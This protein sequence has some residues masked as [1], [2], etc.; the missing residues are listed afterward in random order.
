AP[1]RVRATRERPS[2]SELPVRRN[3]RRLRS[4]TTPSTVP[5]PPH[6]SQG[7]ALPPL[8]HPSARH[9]PIALDRFGRHI[10]DTRRL[11]DTQSGKEPQFDNSRLPL[12]P[13]F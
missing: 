13:T 4:Q 5:N 7:L 2:R 11:L 6:S 1:I 9:R 12:I 8:L 10:E 3:R